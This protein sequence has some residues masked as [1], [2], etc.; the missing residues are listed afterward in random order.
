MSGAVYA[1]EEK[2][3]DIKE[4]SITISAD[5]ADG[6]RHKVKQGDRAEETV[7]GTLVIFGNKVS[8]T[9]T[10]TVVAGEDLKADVVIRNVNIDVSG[11][12]NTAAFKT[13]GDGDVDIEL[14]G[15]NMLKSGSNCAG[16]QKGNSG[17]L[18]IK[19]ENGEKGTVTATG[20]KNGA[21]IGGGDGVSGN[22]ITITG[23]TV[24]AT[25]G[26]KGAGIGGGDGVSG[27]H[28]TIAGG[29]VTAIGGNFRGAGIGGGKN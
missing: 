20:G 2:V 8:S 3:Y 9:N 4:G 21:G 28:I 12:D 24:T 14:D 7:E 26:Q 6:R 16:I 13:E 22:H 11:I 27:N 1:G 17:V 29:T 19:D 5:S 10:I 18:T 25:G 15:E 23:G